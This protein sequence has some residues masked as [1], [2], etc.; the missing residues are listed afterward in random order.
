MEAIQNYLQEYFINS[1]DQYLLIVPRLA[2]TRK[3]SDFTFKVEG[4]QDHKV[5][6]VVLAAQSRVFE[7]FFAKHESVC[8]TS[9]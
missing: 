1:I 4:G 5:N 8:N 6:K 7:N 3:F 2:Q 9:T